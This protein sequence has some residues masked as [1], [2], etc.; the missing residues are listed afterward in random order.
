MIR[1]LDG[2]KRVQFEADA[3]RKLPVNLAKNHMHAN[4][5]EPNSGLI[6]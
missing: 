2:G 1:K 6:S 3:S 5:V 4:Y